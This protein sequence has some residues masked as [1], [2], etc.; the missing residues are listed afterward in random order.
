MAFVKDF[1][2]S[3]SVADALNSLEDIHAE[4]PII[5]GCVSELLVG[6][7]GNV[8]FVGL[9]HAHIL[10]QKITNKKVF[11]HKKSPL[12]GACSGGGV[13]SLEHLLG[14]WLD[15]R[16]GKWASGGDVVGVGCKALG[17]IS[18]ISF[19]V[20]LDLVLGHGHWRCRNVEVRTA[21]GSIG[22]GHIVT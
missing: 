5:R 21:H 16:V 2:D 4:V 7:G 14:L 13:A 9:G 3:E 15:P 22:H 6:E 18:L 1:H 17:L 10:P 20:A 11:L 19:D 8:V 12:S